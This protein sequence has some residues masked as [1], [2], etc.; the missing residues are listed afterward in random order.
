MRTTR[1]TPL[2][3]LLAGVVALS[4]A[5]T[6][7]S[8]AAAEGPPPPGVGVRLLDAP[9]NRA[10][11]PRARVYVV[12]Q[13]KP[14]AVFTRHV[15]VSNGDATAMDLLVYPATAVLR[16]GGFGIAAR[17]APGA[18]PSWTTVSPTSLHLEPGQRTSVTVTFRVP[19]DAPAGEVYGAVVAERPARRTAQGVSVALRAAVRVYLS[20]GAGGEPASDF[21]VDALTAG[22]DSTGSPYVLAQVHNTGGRALDLSG[23]LRLKD[24]PGGLSAGPFAA[25]LGTTLGIGQ[26][27]PVLVPLDKA[28]PAGPWLASLELQ[29]GELE[30][31]VEGTVSFPVRAASQSP[32][33]VP[34]EVPFS[35]ENQLV[36][37]VAIALV[38]VMSLALLVLALLGFL[39]R[40]RADAQ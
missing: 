34:T 6:A 30:R 11:D 19:A 1:A 2:R 8:A 13:V 15:E 5:A 32:P 22:R 28:I 7:S 4:G 23:S 39:R 29:S 21:T 27:G 10:D 35:D 18:V 24:G 16:G 25:R 40:R 26:S 17:G 20:V 38:S 9:S 33:V 3:L 12:D 31:K 36:V 14:G 37:P